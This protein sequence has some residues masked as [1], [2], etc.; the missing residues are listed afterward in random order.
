MMVEWI[1]VANRG[2]HYPMF[3]WDSV[4]EGWRRK[5]LRKSANIPFDF[6]YYRRLDD[7]SSFEKNEWN[8]YFKAVKKVMDHDIEKL[9]KAGRRDLRY[10]NQMIELSEDARKRLL[11]GLSDKELVKLIRTFNEIY[12][13]K[14]GH[15]Y[16]YYALMK[17]IPPI[18]SAE[19]ENLSKK[20]KFSFNDYFTIIVSTP[21]ELKLTKSKKELLRMAMKKEVSSEE[22]REYLKSYGYINRM[23]YYAYHQTEREIRRKIS[24]IDNP[25][26]E[27]SKMLE[28][29]NRE[30]EIEKELEGFE[31]SRNARQLIR[32]IRFYSFLSNHMDE[33]ISLVH[34]NMRFVFEELGRCYGLTF[35]EIVECTIK[36]LYSLK[37]PSK[38]V[39]QE[40]A[41]DYAYFM[42]NCKTKIFTGAAAE[43]AKKSEKKDY[44]HVKELKGT[45]G[46]P[47]YA[48]AKAKIVLKPHEISK[49]EKGD[50]LVAIGTNVEYVSAMEKASAIVTNEG[51]ITCHA[52]I[53]SREL[54]VPCLVGTKIGTEVFQ[55]GD[56]VEVDSDM[57]VVR[58]VESE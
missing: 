8:K 29:E 23:Y 20:G 58:K 21:I 56:F 3:M 13:K 50:V 57:G 33:S 55:D 10:L 32:L 2:S 19:L 26:E 5:M 22:I 38:K 17:I 52:A 7:G 47:G 53:V 31:F 1:E 9:F 40:R 39:L 15:W 48:K 45:C 34:A 30:K 35:N 25:K 18:V 54:G 27:L 49:I 36:E 11:I 4:S 12:I 24:E 42:E 41:K 6:K 14:C 51:G 46:S 37:I 44:S 28:K 43:K 16:T